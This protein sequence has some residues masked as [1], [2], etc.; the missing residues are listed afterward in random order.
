ML[1][2]ERSFWGRLAPILLSQT[3]GVVCGVLGI[4]VVSRLVPPEPLAGYGVFLTFTTLGMWVVHSGLIKY[5]SRNW[6]G[7]WNQQML[8]RHVCGEWTKRIPWLLFA[9]AVGAV[10]TWKLAGISPGHVFGSLFVSCAALS[11]FALAQAGFQAARQH[12]RDFVVSAVGSTGRSFAAPAAYAVTGGAGIALLWGFA[13]AALGVAML[14]GFWLWRST[15]RS[16][17]S[18]MTIPTS[19]P[20]IGFQFAALA[21][22]NWSIYGVNRWI[23]ALVFDDTLAGFF[24]FAGNIGAIPAAILGGI[25]VQYFQPGIYRKADASR[26]ELHDVLRRIDLIS[27]ALVLSGVAAVLITAAVC[28]LLLGTLID[29]RYAPALEWVLP[30]GCFGVTVAAAQF[31]HI[32]LLAFREE[33][34]CMHVDLT[35]AAVLIAAAAISAYAS[36]RAFWWTLTASPICVFLVARTAA[37]WVLRPRS[38][39]R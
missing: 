6:A 7:D 15:S 27:L 35:V 30:T 31:Y 22:A 23:A 3:V 21:L 12:W 36:P 20:Y 8:L 17:A 19:A 10:A 37:A 11:I 33:R 25:F 5:L 1:P 13:G 38:P 9:T 29:M 34:K 18:S 26:V 28:P 4:S 16:V 14:A 24:T 39:A 32:V 2:L